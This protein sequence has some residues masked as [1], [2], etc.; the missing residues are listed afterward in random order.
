MASATTATLTPGEHVWDLEWTA[1]SV[2]RTIVYGVVVVV[3]DV[4][5]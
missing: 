3:D 2:V 4:T 5:A 1:S